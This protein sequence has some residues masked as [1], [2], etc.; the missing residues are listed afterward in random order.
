M[1]LCGL[2]RGVIWILLSDPNWQIEVL[3]S[4]HD[5]EGF[6]CSAKALEN[7]LRNHARQDVKRKLAAVFVLTPDRS[8]IAGY[9]TLSQSAVRLEDIPAGT[10]KRLAKYP[11][12]PATLVGRLAV[13]DKFR[14]HGLGEKL[15]LDAL[16]RS[17][18]HS[19]EIG[20]FAVVVDP[21]GDDAKGF[22]QK[23]GFLGLPG[24]PN[25]LFLPMETIEQLF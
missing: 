3:A 23:Y 17:F 22:Y 8:T 7:Y 21:K 24:V 4:R 25:R 5:R 1:R 18:S 9:Y 20:S 16:H 13:A 12:I 6:V 10:A 15:L 19:A 2:P 11:Q 14:G